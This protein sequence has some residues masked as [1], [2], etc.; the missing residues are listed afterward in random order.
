MNKKNLIFGGL[1]ASLMFFSSC[2][3]EK[4]DEVLNDDSS[5]VAYTEVINNYVDKVVIPTYGDMKDKTSALL[6]AVEAFTESGTD[7]DLQA[8]CDAWRAAREPWEESEAFLFGPA[9]TYGLDP[10]LDSWPLDKVQINSFLNSSIEFDPEALGSTVRGFHTLEYLLFENGKARKASDI[11]ERQKNYM[12][13]VA[14]GIS[15]D[16]FLLWY[17]WHGDKSLSSADKERVEELEPDAANDGFGARFKN[18]NMFDQAYKTQADVIG[19]II[20]GCTDISGEV[21]E[22]KIGGPFNTKQVEEVES[23]YSWNSLDDYKH[24]ILSIQH[25]YL[26]TLSDKIG[27]LDKTGSASSISGVVAGKNK[28]LDEQI[29]KAI[30]DAY[31]AVDAIPAPFRNNLNASTEIKD[32]MEKLAELTDVLE[33]VKEVIE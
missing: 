30:K 6:E 19:Q 11:T 16:A 29:R 17:Y 20:D 27:D 3:D 23:W 1:L 28:N 26:G 15:D 13:A 10:S 12:V 32:A 21:G 24:N 33:K 8:A 7:S 4:K 2:D 14:T 31:N 18:A 9:A 22:Q 25:S 5:S